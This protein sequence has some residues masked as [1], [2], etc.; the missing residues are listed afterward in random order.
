M[1][2][3]KTNLIESVVNNGYCVGCG[4][5]AAVTS[6]PYEMTTNSIGQYEAQLDRKKNLETE[7]TRVCESVCP[8]S[9]TS[10]NE[11]EIGRS[12]Y[13]KDCSHNP[14]VGYYRN[15]YAG[16]VVEG[17]FRKLG[18]SGGFGT[19]LLHELFRTDRIDAVIHVQPSDTN[20]EKKFIYTISHSL[21]DIQSGS[22]SRY[23][24]IELS[25]V[26]K[27]VRENPSRYA[28]IGLPCFIK[29]VRL[30]A[31]VD[32]VISD[33]I[34]YCIGLVCGGLKSIH[35]ADSLAWQVG[36]TP[37]ALDNIDFRI[38]DAEAAAN[39]YSTLVSSR[40]GEVIIPTNQLFGTDWGIGAF[41]YKS[42]DFCDDVFA[43]TADV[44]LGDAWLPEY[45][46]DGSGT[47]VL[48][49]RSDDIFNMVE[50]AIEEGRVK[51]DDIKIE[52]AIA[53]QDAGIRHR[54]HALSYRLQ[55]EKEKG[56]W[57]PP[58][59][60]DVDSFNISEFEKRRQELRIKMR[61]TSH[62]AFQSA[63]KNDDINIYINEMTPIYKNYKDIKGSRLERVSK[64]TKRVSNFIKRKL[65]QLSND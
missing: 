6:S 32:K 12:L 37:Q 64:F 42:C 28:I 44:V 52:R 16:Y 10:K 23:Y 49:V 25:E 41:K 35:Y 47:N 4:A 5:C 54:K 31:S 65:R 19:W 62:C 14:N 8:F 56:N 57:T 40:A 48:V 36:V 7:V 59:R 63:L 18:S 29:S 58:K 21:D 53:S 2:V 15:A 45:V 30:V 1:T 11:D 39:K 46:H 9:S 20:S 17:D 27:I 26:V 34:R 33:R 51:L 60:V 13:S 50:A 43:E 22:K 24:P 3:F 38:K 61:D 55:L